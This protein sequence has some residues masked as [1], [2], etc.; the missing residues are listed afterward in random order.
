[1]KVMEINSDFVFQII[2]VNL[3][4]LQHIHENH[5]KG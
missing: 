3:A 4:Q 2:L 1:M 5:E